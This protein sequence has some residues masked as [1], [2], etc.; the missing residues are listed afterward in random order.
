M[1]P[2]GFIIIGGLV[3]A[4]WIATKIGADHSREVCAEA[5]LKGSLG[6]R[7][8]LAKEEWET[9]S[10]EEKAEYFRGSTD[11]LWKDDSFYENPLYSGIEG[12]KY[13]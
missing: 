10:D 13:S 5:H 9:M 4:I 8:R 1:E 11:S 7:I 6:E 3:L 2:I 12:N